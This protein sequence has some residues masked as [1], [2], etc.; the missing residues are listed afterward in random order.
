MLTL[1]CPDYFIWLLFINISCTK[2][3]QI[4]V[5]KILLASFSSKDN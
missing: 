3:I 4:S 2:M 1:L 5:L